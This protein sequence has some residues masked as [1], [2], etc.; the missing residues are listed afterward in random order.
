[1]FALNL[2]KDAGYQHNIM[3]VCPG[4]AKRAPIESMQFALK[5]ALVRKSVIVGNETLSPEDFLETSRILKVRTP[6]NRVIASSPSIPLAQ[7]RAATAAKSSVAALRFK[8]KAVMPTLAPGMGQRYDPGSCESHSLVLSIGA[9]KV[10]LVLRFSTW[11]A[12]RNQAQG[13]SRGYLNPGDLCVDR[14]TDHVCLRVC[15]HTC[16]ALVYLRGREMSFTGS[17]PWTIDLTLPEA[18]AANYRPLY[19]PAEKPYHV[20]HDKHWVLNQAHGF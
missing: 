19:C 15:K 17:A 9:A 8:F 10:E 6:R 12:F 1:M 4:T 5:A 14:H 2:I 18:P 3:F 13:V 11:D 20:D 16:A 7:L